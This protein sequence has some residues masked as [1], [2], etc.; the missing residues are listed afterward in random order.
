MI[1][2]TDLIE[3]FDA[4]GEEPGYSLID[5]LQVNELNKVEFMTLKKSSIS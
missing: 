1:E 5:I 3:V 2:A 4:F